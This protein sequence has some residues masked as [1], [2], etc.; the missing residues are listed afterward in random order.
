ML[1][2]LLR[3]IDEVFFGGT[4]HELEAALPVQVHTLP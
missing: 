1:Q 2:E 3:I 4:L